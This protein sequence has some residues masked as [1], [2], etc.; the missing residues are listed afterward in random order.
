M[1]PNAGDISDV[2]RQIAR[3]PRCSSRLSWETTIRCYNAD[4]PYAEVGFP[5]HRGQPVLIDFDKSVF[6]R[7][8]YTEESAGSAFPIPSKIVTAISR[9]VEG[10]NPAAPLNCRRFLEYTRN[11]SSHPLVL[12]I[13]GGEIGSGAEALYAADDVTIIGTDIYASE[14]TALLADAHAL[15]FADQ[16]F[17]AVW[18]QAVLEHVLEPHS[19]AEEI[20]RI[21]KPGGIVFADTPFM[22]QVHGYA[23]DFTRFTLSG[24]RWLFRRFDELHAGVA[25]GPGTALF[26]SIRYAMKAL[27]V[28]NKVAFAVAAPLFW[29]RF[30]DK[31]ARG[32][33]AA[34]AA[35]GLFFM[36]TK[37]LRAMTPKEVIS[38]YDSHRQLH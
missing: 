25:G 3:C 17:D 21:L 7:D 38:Y 37:S 14:N 9:I 24:H 27:G 35:S 20:Y 36:G 15:P 10:R 4:C 5:V 31:V 12:V 29:V 28:G 2:V 34:D 6:P 11:M 30:I 16:S 23:Y 13:G 18:I 33:R 19:V 8:L 26:W 22:Q 1:R 32:G